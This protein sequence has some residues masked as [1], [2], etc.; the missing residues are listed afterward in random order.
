MEYY[1]FV[2]LNECQYFPCHEGI[3]G[4]KFN[5]KF[6]FCPLYF[7]QC[8]G[9]FEILDN[10][11]KDCSNCLIP[12]QGEEGY[13]WMLNRIREKLKDHEFEKKNN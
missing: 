8:G 1:K 2:Q 5:C 3:D 11:V 13:A 9:N 10:G 6:C 4:E 7:T 12:H